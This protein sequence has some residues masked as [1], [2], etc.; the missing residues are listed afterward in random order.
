MIK[1]D[2]KQPES[3]AA[4]SF[5]EALEI[6]N[7]IGYPLMVRPSFVLGGRAMEVVY[8]EAPLTRYAREAIKISPEY[9]CSS[10]GS[11]RTPSR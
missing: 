11:L 3:G 7:R 10:T 4:R 9:P 2:I 6:A 5:E 8:D 1:L